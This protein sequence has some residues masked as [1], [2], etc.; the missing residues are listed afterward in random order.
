MIRAFRSQMD[1]ADP[2]IQK[3]ALNRHDKIT[4]IGYGKTGLQKSN[5]GIADDIFIK[6]P[7]LSM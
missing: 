7:A 1:I 3:I 2:T 4:A 5:C 6:Q